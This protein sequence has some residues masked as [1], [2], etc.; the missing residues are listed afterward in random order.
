MPLRSAN[1]TV[2]VAPMKPS[3][4]PS[5]LQPLL[6][7]VA[8]ILL[9]FLFTGEIRDTDIWLHLKTGQHTW[10]T[11]ALTVPD[12]FSFTSGMGAA[13]YRGEE[14]T[15]YF[16]LT[17]E[18]LAQ[19]VMFLIYSAAGFPGLVLAR[20]ALLMVF[21]ALAGWMA[22]RRTNDFYMSLAAAL[23]CAAMA[24]HFQQS[25][26][27]LVTFVFFAVT[28]AILESRRWMW[29]LPVI[30]LIW[31]NCHAGFF[32][33]WLVFAAYCGE[34]V[35]ERLRKRPIQNERQLW[36]VAVTCFLVS[37]LNPNGY[38]VIQILFLYRS[39]GIQSENLEWQRPIFWE[40]GIY[41]FVLFG[42]LLA[43]L[44]AR[45]RTRPADWLLYFGFALISLMALRN[46]IFL[47]LIGPV[48]MAAYVPSGAGLNPARRL[49]RRSLDRVPSCSGSIKN[50]SH[51][52]RQQ[53]SGYF[54]TIAN[55]R[56]LRVIAPML[57]TAALLIYDVAPAIAGHNAFA[58]HAADWQLPS[59]AANFIQASQVS[60]RMFNNYET[61]GYLVWR[62]W[63]LQRDF[64]DPRG[65]SEEVYADYKRILTNTD[66]STEKLLQKYGIQ[67]VVVEGFDYLSGQV[68]PLVMELADS[69]NAEWKLAYSDS[70]S[71]IFMRHP[72]AGVE[73][74]NSREAL[75]DSLEKQCGV[76]L[77]H[78]PARPYCARGL[79]EVYA[80]TGNVDQARRW[81]EY[82]LE[83]KTAPDPEAEQTYQSLHVTSLSNA[84]LSLESK[85]D[86]DGAEP[87]FRSALEI[88][89]K[90][91]GPNHPDTAGSLNNLAALLESKGDYAAAEPLY[92]R[93]LAIAEKTLGPNHPNTATSLDNLAG[94]LESEGDDAAAEPLYRRAL[95]T[96]E[97]ALGP[98]DPTTQEIRQNLDAL[99]KKRAK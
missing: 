9:L 54:L 76:H 65:L 11:R 72:P 62:L 67:M 28:M 44:L 89:E 38:R 14:V 26:P 47:G 10:E 31:A 7:T 32:I 22:F 91:L 80:F 99:L 70:T 52:R 5:W 48:L 93:A 30:F 21:S 58:L 50:R 60:T 74:R 18:W 13:K 45:R 37:G 95:S 68:Y 17:H 40:P 6:L 23:A 56:T 39:S 69:G 75:L 35:I 94:L 66:Q 49:H 82:Y 34:A 78:D 88:A 97:K 24:F 2:S 63:P 8:A 15:R 84:A 83:H 86:L 87:L 55:W 20:A 16:N 71:V 81:M 51:P 46:T 61:G 33:G 36:L 1:R 92:R 85:G 96:A 53:W 79:S 29:A 98:D 77:Q 57:A 19:V 43:L 64:I 12:P 42:S 25:R 4:A 27:F 73:P 90:S 59:G 41:S 3:A